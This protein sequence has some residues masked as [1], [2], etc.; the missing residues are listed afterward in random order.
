[1]S[2]KDSMLER[3]MLGA[4]LPGE[5]PP[6]LPLVELIGERRVLIENHRGVIAYGCNEI[7]VKVQYGL[8][9]VKGCELMLA[10]MTKDQLVITGKI[11]C[12]SVFRGR[13]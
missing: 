7:C 8:L 1:M 4:D 12:I 3:F 2:W 10:K 6:G 5:L 11:D 9:T 13:K